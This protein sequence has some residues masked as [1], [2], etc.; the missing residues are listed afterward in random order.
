MR[1][2]YLFG[3]L[4][5]AAACLPAGAMKEAAV[6]ERLAQTITVT[7]TGDRLAAVLERLSE[8]T[9]VKMSAAKPLFD[10]LVVIRYVGTL[11]GFQQVVAEFFA[12]DEETIARWGRDD[13]GGYRLTRSIEALNQ[14][15]QERATAMTRALDQAVC[16]GQQWVR[17][18]AVLTD[19]ERAHLY[20][21]GTASRHA[22]VFGGRKF[23]DAQMGQDA[24]NWSD[25]VTVTWQM[26]GR[27]PLTRMFTRTYTDNQFGTTATEG[28]ALAQI[29]PQFTP[30]RQQQDWRNRYGDPA[31]TGGKALTVRTGEVKEGQEIPRRTLLLRIAEKANV[32]L[33]ADEA[34]QTLLE[35]R[36]PA[37]GTVAE[38]LDAACAFQWGSG[39]SNDTNHGS[40][41]RLSGST[42]LVRSLGWPEEESAR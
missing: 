17:H 2:R 6:D 38:L 25:D 26:T 23:I 5:L 18:L 27:S 19:D 21:G 31:P 13:E 16:D 39:E 40:V 34:G 30:E 20:A 42:Y 9:G 36:Q 4:L 3:V 8:K 1:H 29:C 24:E 14:L 22:E 10:T 37:V 32:N 12:I 15:R 11:G 41:W 7:E 35:D 28:F 33:I